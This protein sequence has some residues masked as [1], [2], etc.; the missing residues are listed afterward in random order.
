MEGESYDHIFKI[1]LLGDSGV[2]KSNLV[3]RF[4]KNEFNQDSKS[5]IGVEFATK[6]VQIED[7]KMVKAQIWDTAGQER[8]RSIASSYYRGALGAL[9]VYDI[10]DQNSFN[11]APMWLKEVEENSE[12]DCLIMLVGNKMDLTEQR[13]VSVRDGRSYAR[14]NGLAFIETS[15]LDSTGVETAFQRILQEIYKQQ[16]KKVL[17]SESQEQFSRGSTPINMNSSSQGKSSCC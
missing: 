1:V 13:Q 5:T 12:K 10:T 4:T 17:D 16:A 3:W 8:Y 2:G 9:L 14:K 11:N 6:T 15:A 7:N